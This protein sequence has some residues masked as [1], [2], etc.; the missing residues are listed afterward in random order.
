MAPRILV[1]GGNGFVGRHLL[2]LVLREQPD[3]TVFA[4]QREPAA[5][6]PPPR[7]LATRVTWTTVE[8]LD[9]AAVRESLSA[10]RPDQV[11][12]L[13]GISHV[14]GSWQDT[15]STLEVNVVGTHLLLDELRRQQLDARVLV[16]GSATIYAAREEALTERHPLEPASPY[17]L[18]KLAQELL[19]LRAW[20]DD[21]QRV[22]VVR[23]FNHIGPGQHPSFFAPGFARQ[24][25]AI[26]AGQ[27]PPVL[28]VGNL[29]ARRD[30][31][32]VRD[33]VRAY[34]ALMER[35]QPGRPYNVCSGR[36][37]KVG[38]V[39]GALCASC[40]VPVQVEVDPARLRPNDTPLV[41]GSFARLQEDTGWA[42]QVPFE[43][44]LRDVMD[45]ARRA[46]T[47]VRP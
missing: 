35:G 5:E 32:D 41:L 14:G 18:S 20:K 12:H 13:A 40:R 28:R 8:L 33:T 9:R 47:A 11:Y 25:A 36:A 42:P 26:E 2:A 22:L 10:A 21:G 15:A 27:A 45:D 44:T 43:N 1:T 34:A 38:D 7:E 19:S 17:A 29:E 4:W 3:A 39:L 24:L 46:L 16:T 23:A 30:L 31:T 37:T 6:A